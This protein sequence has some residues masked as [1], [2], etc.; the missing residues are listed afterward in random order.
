M[1][2][3]RKLPTNLIEAARYFED[4]DV[5]TEFVAQ[6]RWPDGPVCPQCGEREHYYLAKRR[7]WKCKACKKQFSVKQ[8]SIFEDS[9]IPLDK[10]L[11]SIWLI[12]NS[13]NGVSSH[14]LGR[15]VGISQKSAWFVLHRIRLAMQTKSF[16]KFTGEVEVD[17][18]YVGG[19]LKN[20]HLAVRVQRDDLAV[21]GPRSNKTIV[22]GV[23]ERGGQVRASVIQDTS[24]RT[25]TGHVGA[26]VEKGATVYSDAHKGY[27]PLWRNYIHD[28]VDHTTQYVNGR[29]HTNGI[30]NFWSL[31]KRGIHGT[32]VSIAPEH[33]FRYV[34]ERCFTYNTRD[35]TDLGRFSAVLGAVAG[36]RLTWAELTRV[37]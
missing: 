33:L 26:H 19:K 2:E 23:L 10:W 25:L 15:S 32:Y 5:A 3:D 24:Q 18:T 11:L 37:G 9:A 29:V 36:K 20:M 8:G 16:D 17:E 7:V 35:L 12:A 31:L 22:A 4:P 6:L 27:T 13:K 1:A 34:D 21:T 30:E 28:F 14:E